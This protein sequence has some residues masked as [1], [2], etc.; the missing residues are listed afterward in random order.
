MTITIAVVDDLTVHIGIGKWIEHLGVAVI[1][2]LVIS[3][4]FLV[5]DVGGDCLE[6]RDRG[7]AREGP[8]DICRLNRS[9]V[10]ESPDLPSEQHRWLLRGR[11]V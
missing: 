7:Q 4:L 2:T 6:R 1:E 5:V 10:P 9:Y 11:S 8:Q 3:D